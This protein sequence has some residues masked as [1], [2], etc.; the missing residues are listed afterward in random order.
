MGLIALVGCVLIFV[1]IIFTVVVTKNIIKTE[2]EKP[3]YKNDYAEW[4]HVKDF[5]NIL[6]EEKKE[7]F[8]EE[9][10]QTVGAVL[11]LFTAP[12]DSEDIQEE[13][14]YEDDI[15]DF[16]NEYETRSFEDDN[17]IDLDI[18]TDLIDESKFE[19]DKASISVTL[20]Y[21]DG[22]ID[23]VM[24]MAEPQITVGREIGS[25]LLLSGYSFIS[26]N[27]AIFSIRDGKLFLED[28]NSK[29]GTK[30]NG[31]KIQGEVAIEESCQVT[32]GKMNIDV[33][34]SEDEV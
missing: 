26:R 33:I 8:K 15:W 24:K 1:L 6:E 21:K 11:D 10:I 16:E 12:S 2:E 5:K 30:V 9:E 20:K 31:E 25:A 14:M 13:D 18:T 19:E 7:D 3:E 34:I 17:E 23:K 32:F 28:L 4:N 27:H 22:D 29:N